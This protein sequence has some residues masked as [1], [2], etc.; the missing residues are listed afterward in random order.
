MWGV[1]F[2]LVTTTACLSLL[3]GTRYLAAEQAVE[4][5]LYVQSSINGMLS[6]LKDAETGQRGYILTADPQFLEPYDAALGEIAGAF[7]RVEALLYVEH[8]QRARIQQL[9]RLIREKL[10]FMAETIRLRRARHEEQA[11]ARVRTGQGKRIM[12]A[13]RAVSRSMLRDEEARLASRKAEAAQAELTA[14]WGVGAGS[15]LAVLLAL[16]SLITVHRD[17][18]ALRRVADEL[19]E[20]EEYYRLLTEHSSDLVRL[21]SA[22]GRVLYVSPSVERMLGYSVAEYMQLTPRSLLHPDEQHI[23]SE[24]LDA[25]RTGA[26]N[27][28]VSSYRIRHRSGAYRWFEVRWVVRRSAD[29]AVRDIHSVARDFTERLEAE[30]QLNAHAAELQR[31][32]LRDE[33]TGLYN[34]RGFL[35]VAGQVYAGAQRD[36]RPAAVLF[37]DLDGM[38]KINDEQGHEVGDLALV[39]TAQ[40]LR[41]ELREADVIGRLGGDEFV[42][43]A[44][45][46]SADDLRSLRERLQGR[47]DRLT[48][49]RR[50]NFALAMSVGAAYSPA[51][52]ALPLTALL[53]Q[54]DAAMYEHKHAR[55]AKRML[56]ASQS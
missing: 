28:G 4:H 23:A 29:G 30:H 41:S 36:A 47:A 49:E 18:E 53:D 46:F 43:F 22:E 51:G 42:V 50:R 52:S 15:V 34:R 13:I 9:R 19:R 25:I 11:L 56:R 16:L 8:A 20:R 44:V 35:E 1:I 48:S 40:V 45:D 7:S 31:I 32:S 38:K 3:S 24:L 54:S 26:R 21:L 55:R 2:A 6:V 33:L 14:R 37:L 12:D 5:T 39:D 27:D 17:A 10:Q